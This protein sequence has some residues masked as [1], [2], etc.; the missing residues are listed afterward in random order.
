[1]ATT[2]GRGGGEEEAAVVVEALVRALR[3][4]PGGEEQGKGEEELQSVVAAVTSGS[5][6]RRERTAAAL[7]GSEAVAQALAWR[8]YSGLGG[9]SSSSENA[10]GQR[11]DPVCGW[12][13]EWLQAG[14]APLRTFVLGCVPA[15]L[16]TYV[17]GTHVSGT[18]AITTTTAAAEATTAMASSAA[19]PMPQVQVTT[20]AGVEACLLCMLN[21]EI[22]DE[23]AGLSTPFALPP[24]EGVPN[25]F[26]PQ[27]ATTTVA[28]TADALRSHN[29]IPGGPSQAQR[30]AGQQAEAMDM[31]PVSE[32]QRLMR[33]AVAQL[34]TALPVLPLGARQRFCEV[35]ARI[36]AFGVPAGVSTGT[37]G[38]VRGCGE[39]RAAELFPG[40][41]SAQA[42]FLCEHFPRAAAV[43]A[44][45]IGASSQQQQQQQQQMR[46]VALSAD[47]LVE[48]ISGLA[49]CCHTRE[50]RDFVLVAC[51]AIESVAAFACQPQ[52]L[53]GARAL[54][55]VVRRLDDED[56]ADG[57]PRK[58]RS[59]GAA[60][61]SSVKTTTTAAAARGTAG[62]RDKSGKQ[63]TGTTTGTKKTV[64]TITTKTRDG[65]GKES[66]EEEEEEEEDNVT[67]ESEDEDETSNDGD[68]DDAAADT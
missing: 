8:L 68:D 52:P 61:V 57:N 46:R 38:E 7:A 5:L 10:P 18:A 17:V 50:L 47:L 35:V 6:V 44:A 55:R 13:Y 31:V 42:T 26:Q 16:W 43:A 49:R 67:D 20:P 27:P 58:P 14:S 45:A 64:A 24:Q 37:A 33:A 60:G 56:A 41:S 62:A 32:R 59:V 4:R 53:L 28:L 12:L 19:A 39:A 29:R 65:S 34:N 1:V 48:F 36:A 21:A 15:L 66:S 11:G 51:R 23:R 30:A 9:G 3:P 63:T 40:I 2:G 22:E 25:V 54:Q